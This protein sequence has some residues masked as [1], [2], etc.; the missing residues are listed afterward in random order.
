MWRA[1]AVEVFGVG[2]RAR[3]EQVDARAAPSTGQRAGG[4]DQGRVQRVVPARVVALRSRV[5]AMLEDLDRPAC[6]F[7]GAHQGDGR[8]GKEVGQ[9]RERHVPPG[10]IE[11]RVV[12]RRDRLFELRRNSGA[13]ADNRIGPRRNVASVATTP[14]VDA[15]RGH[16]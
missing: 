16:L 6:V 10:W 9:W 11:C 15:A 4:M 8:R 2:R 12:E 5:V 14:A 1:V 13:Q 7:L 3:V